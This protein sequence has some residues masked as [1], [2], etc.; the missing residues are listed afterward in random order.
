MHTS[1]IEAMH[2]ALVVANKELAAFANV[3]RSEIAE[4]D[5]RERA[6]RLDQGRSGTPTSDVK[7]ES[8]ITEKPP[9]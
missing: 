2:L 1:A 9:G 4:M 7:N 6:V 3:L 5:K 8:G